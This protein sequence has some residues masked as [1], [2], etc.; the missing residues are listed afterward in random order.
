MQERQRRGN[1]DSGQRE[2]K[3]LNGGLESLK[4]TADTR[5]L[6]VAVHCFTAKGAKIAKTMLPKLCILC[7]LI[8]H[9]LYILIAIHI[10]GSTHQHPR[11]L[12]AHTD[13]NPRSAHDY[14]HPVSS[15]GRGEVQNESR[16]ELFQFHY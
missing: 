14:S 4:I 6:K 13:H 1:G 16:L 11:P 15:A 9:K 2:N 3:G 8:F 5:R 10:N 7:V 12:P